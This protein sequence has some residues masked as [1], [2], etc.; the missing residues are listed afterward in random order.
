MSGTCKQDSGRLLRV[1]AHDLKKYIEKEYVKETLYQRAVSYYHPGILA[2][3]EIT[4][5]KVKR[6]IEDDVAR[7]QPVGESNS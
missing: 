6:T 2:S 1:E 5:D 7:G 4:I 3:L